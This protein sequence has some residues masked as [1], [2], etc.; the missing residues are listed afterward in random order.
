M[1]CAS[2]DEYYMLHCVVDGLIIC[3]RAVCT[4]DRDG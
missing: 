1:Q 4:T 2:C 3:D